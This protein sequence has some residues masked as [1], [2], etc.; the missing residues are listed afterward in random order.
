LV[1]AVRAGTI[2]SIEEVITEK[3]KGKSEIVGVIT[4]MPLRAAYGCTVHKTQG[5]TLDRVQVNIRD[6]FF[7]QPGMLFVALSRARTIEGLRIVG[8][9]RG[10]IERCRIDPRVQPWL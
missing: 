8:D 5:L 7:R 2:P 4:Y 9:Q 1:A 10:F 6:P 3:G